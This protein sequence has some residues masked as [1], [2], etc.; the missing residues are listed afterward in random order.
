MYKMI[1]NYITQIG[2]I[3]KIGEVVHIKRKN[4]PDLYKKVLT[5]ESEDGQISFPEVRNSKLKI[6]DAI[7]EGDKVEIKFTLEGSEKNSKR[8]NNIYT[9][10]IKKV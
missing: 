7:E 2:T 8:Y 3:K 1:K 6:L 4:I 10:S 9:Y 5:F